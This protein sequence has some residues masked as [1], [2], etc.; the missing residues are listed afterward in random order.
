ME[1][2]NEFANVIESVIFADSSAAT[3]ASNSSPLIMPSS[4]AEKTTWRLE[5]VNV[6]ILERLKTTRVC[7]AISID[8]P[9]CQLGVLSRFVPFAKSAVISNSSPVSR[10][11]PIAMSS[12]F[13]EVP[14]KSID[15]E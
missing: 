12:L 11:M 2:N 15:I 4:S 9:C 10:F 3:T 1:S 6:G 7:S 14:A 13:P 8:S 5:R